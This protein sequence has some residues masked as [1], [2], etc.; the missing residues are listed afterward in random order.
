MVKASG[1]LNRTPGAPLPA[2]DTAGELAT[3]G[4]QQTGQLERA[5]ADKDGAAGI[6]TTCQAWQ[7][8]ASKAAQPKPWWKFWG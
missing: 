7:D 4:I 2:S 5:N 6:L 8:K 1:L 3:F